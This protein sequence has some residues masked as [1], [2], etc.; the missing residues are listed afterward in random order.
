M[1]DLILIDMLKKMDTKDLD[2][3]KQT[4]FFIH[5]IKKLDT[6]TDSR[7]I[8]IN[9]DRYNLLFEYSL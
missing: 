3:Q 1:V 8:N 7:I 6:N 2:R 4:L 9:T 5:K